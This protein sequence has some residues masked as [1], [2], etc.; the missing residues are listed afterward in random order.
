MPTYNYLEFKHFIHQ[1]FKEKQ[2]DSILKR[3][4]SLLVY[5]FIVSGV[6]LPKFWNPDGVYNPSFGQKRTIFK[7]I[8]IMI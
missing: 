7:M 5:M 4:I 8:H 2:I 6:I 3:K 1:T